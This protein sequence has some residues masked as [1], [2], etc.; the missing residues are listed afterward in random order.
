MSLPPKR[1][2]QLLEVANVLLALSLFARWYL[3]TGTTLQT[4]FSETDTMESLHIPGAVQQRIEFLGPTITVEDIIRELHA[5]PEYLQTDKSKQLLKEMQQTQQSLLSNEEA[6]QKVELELNRITFD[7]FNG[8]SGTEQA[9][10]RSR[11]NTDSIEG[12]EAQY[13]KELQKQMEGTP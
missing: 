3:T 5:H 9:L 4:L 10:I 11:R 12:V 8:L 13:W 1:W 7:I 2:V 6:L